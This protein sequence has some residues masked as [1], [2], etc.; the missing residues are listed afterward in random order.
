MRACACSSTDCCFNGFCWG[1]N[2]GGGHPTT[3]GQGIG[4]GCK[5]E[6]AP[7]CSENLACARE[8]LHA[9]LRVCVCVIVQV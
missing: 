1:L 5:L 2:L 6:C 8:R 7:R 4:H 3:T 9:L